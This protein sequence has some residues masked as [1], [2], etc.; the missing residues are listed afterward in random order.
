M[1]AS[2][3][4][5]EVIDPRKEKGVLTPG[6]MDVFSLLEATPQYE[7]EDFT[8]YPQQKNEIE[9]NDVIDEKKLDE[10]EQV[11]DLV[12]AYF[13]SMGKIAILTRDEEAVLAGTIEKG[14][15]FLV[16]SMTKMPLYKKLEATSNSTQEDINS[17]E[18]RSDEILNSSLEILDNLMS[19]IRVA[20]EKIEQYGTL[21]NLK[22]LIKEKRR[23]HINLVKLDIIA[24]EVQREYRYIESETGIKID[25]LKPLYE[26][27]TKTR[28]LVTEARKE[29]ITRNLRLVISVAKHYLGKG[30]SF[31]DLIQEGNIGL[32]RAI[33]KF[34]YKK[35]F[36][37]ST[38]A[39]CWIKQC[40]TRAIM[41]QAKTIRVPVHVMELYN[42]ITK[43]SRTLVPQLGRE[44]HAEE[45]AQGLGISARKVEMVLETVQDTV[46]LQTPVGDD[47]TTLE[48]FIRDNS[49]VSPYHNVEQNIISERTLKIL[50]T[51][52]PKEE[53]V[54]RMRYGI[55]TDT[56]HTLE[57]VGRHFSVTRERIRQIE[58]KAMRKLKHPTRCRLLKTLY[59]V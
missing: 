6:E 30:L 53:R 45:I 51:L 17:D 15:E 56:D 10:Y 36:K 59:A 48:D 12:Q 50:K 29:F 42:S 46:S 7:F 2:D 32:M 13:H 5:E 16:R 43:V 44:P 54:I 35:G 52:A 18:D 4:L 11:R 55:G 37:F 49:T 24:K 21:Q 57:E 58:S 9:D 33:D 28:Q 39:I 1:R 3:I 19:R 14:K 40:I 23:R 41:D 31:L 20:D 47:E 8:D 27:M 22:K 26:E 34:D 38:Y 25:K